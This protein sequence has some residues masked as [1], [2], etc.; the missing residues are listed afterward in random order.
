MDESPDELYRALSLATDEELD[1]IASLLFR[2]QF[3]PLDYLT[4]PPI[5]EVQSKSREE[6]ITMI[7][8][9]F[10]FLAADGLTVLRGKA[11]QLTYRYVLERVCRYLKIKYKRTQTVP[12]IESELFLGLIERSWRNLTPSE[13]SAM[14]SP[15]QGELPATSATG[16]IIKG[17][18]AIAM[19]KLRSQITAMLARKTAVSAI[20]QYAAARTVLGILTP[21]LWGIFL[22][23]LG[24]RTIATNYSRV[25]PVIFIL[26]QIRL[27]RES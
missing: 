23:D 20:G 14:A 25:I 1:Q 18:T 11:R 22:A 27:L 6:L 3:N 26:A 21:T 9:R 24:W 16:L 7:A 13:Q 10:K 17:G 4:I 19:T 8:H 15:V 2:R 5:A 12:E